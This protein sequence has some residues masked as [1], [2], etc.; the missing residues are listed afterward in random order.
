MKYVKDPNNRDRST[1]SEQ[2][3]QA[4]RTSE[5]IGYHK[6]KSRES[7]YC[8]RLREGFEMMETED[9]LNEPG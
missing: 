2:I 5:D 4:R 1:R 6:R 8:R 7:S 9:Y 3:E